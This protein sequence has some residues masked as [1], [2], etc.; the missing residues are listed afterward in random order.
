V[1]ADLKTR[2]CHPTETITR[3]I[4][5]RPRTGLLRIGGAGQSL[6]FDQPANGGSEDSGGRGSCRAFE[7]VCVACC[8]K[9]SCGATG[10]LIL[11]NPNSTTN[12]SRALARHVGPSATSPSAPTMRYA[13]RACGRAH[14]E[15]RQATETKS[16]NITKP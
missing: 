14:V 11:M 5:A 3:G 12:R 13:R 1:I 6:A 7:L 2:Y 15:S 16:S 8:C 10:M 4:F 9:Y